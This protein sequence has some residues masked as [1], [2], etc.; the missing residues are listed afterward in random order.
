MRRRFFCAEKHRTREPSPCAILACVIS[1]KQPT[2]LKLI[3]PEL[4]DSGGRRSGIGIQGDREIRDRK[5][6]DDS[7]VLR[8]ITQENRP[9][10]RLAKSR[11]FS[12]AS[13][14]SALAL[15]EN[16]PT[17][18]RYRR[19]GSLSAST[20]L[21]SAHNVSIGLLCFGSQLFWSALL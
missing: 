7:S 16:A 2:W 11:A 10:V 3:T 8:N 20:R 14:A 19:V 6:R 13:M 5:A 17:W 21:T 18:T 9:P 1:K 15:I 4:G 12:L